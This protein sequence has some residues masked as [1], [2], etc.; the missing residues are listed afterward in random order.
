MNLCGLYD[1]GKNALTKFSIYITINRNH[2]EM[3]LCGLYGNCKN[4]LIWFNIYIMINRYHE[5]NTFFFLRL[6]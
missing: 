6:S 2:N 3:N 5:T 4:A 1:N